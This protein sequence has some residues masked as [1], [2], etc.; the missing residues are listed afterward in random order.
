MTAAV[1]IALLV[2]TWRGQ[3][4]HFPFGPFRMYSTTNE[5]SGRITKINFIGIT[6]QG[7]HVRIRSSRFGMRPAEV[8]GQMPRIRRSPELLAY[9]VEAYETFNPS[10]PRLHEFQVVYG[11]HHLADRAPVSYEEKVIARWQR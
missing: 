7:E 2:G 5:P 4:D 11:I 8:D 3:D 1:L 9:L 6:E 10:A